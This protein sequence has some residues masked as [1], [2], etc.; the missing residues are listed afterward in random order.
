MET[1]LQ[2]IE[3]RLDLND[4]KKKQYIK[5]LEHINFLNVIGDKFKIHI[6]SS[7]PK[8]YLHKLGLK[9][10]SRVKDGLKTILFEQGKSSKTLIVPN[11]EL[12][13]IIQKQS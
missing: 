10:I 4:L 12:T 9:P 11:S 7:I 3:G 1:L 13:R 2:F 8:V 6:I 5:D